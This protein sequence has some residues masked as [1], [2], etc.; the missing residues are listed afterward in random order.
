MVLPLEL[1]MMPLEEVND[2]FKMLEEREVFG[3]VVLKP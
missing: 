1:I 3:K 2:A